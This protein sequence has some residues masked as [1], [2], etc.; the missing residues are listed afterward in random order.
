M[1]EVH[2]PHT[3]HAQGSAGNLLF[4]RKQRYCFRT[5]SSNS[6]S[7]FSYSFI[8]SGSCVQS[9]PSVNCAIITVTLSRLFFLRLSRT[10]WEA[11]SPRSVEGSLRIAS[12]T[13]VA[14]SCPDMTSHT[15][16]QQMTQMVPGRRL[17]TSY[18]SGTHETFCVGTGRLASA[19]Y[20]KSPSPRLTARLPSS[21][22]GSSS[23]TEP[24]AVSIRFLSVGWLGLW[25]ML[26]TMIGQANSEAVQHFSTASAL[27]CNASKCC[28]I[29]TGIFGADASSSV[30]PLTT[31]PRESPQLSSFKL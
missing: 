26:S 1:L 6:L 12:R 7:R 24:P 2:L 21:R 18:M 20:S 29:L 4:F 23:E 3:A 13:K 16:S 30:G 22:G 8:S 14:T 25:S 19:L 17:D 28:G 10:I 9:D 11:R 15:P 27:P 31:S 5:S